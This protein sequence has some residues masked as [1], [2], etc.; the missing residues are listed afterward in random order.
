MYVDSKSIINYDHPNNQT[1]INDNTISQDV[2]TSVPE[3]V[4]YMCVCL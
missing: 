3:R 2:K 1:I 4:N